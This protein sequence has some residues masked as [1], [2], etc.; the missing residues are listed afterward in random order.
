M[1][2]VLVDCTVYGISSLTESSSRCERVPSPAHVDYG[3]GTARAS[4]KRT[5]RRAS[6]QHGNAQCADSDC[7]QECCLSRFMRTLF[8]LL[9][10]SLQLPFPHLYQWHATE[11]RALLSERDNCVTRLVVSAPSES[12]HIVGA[13]R[14]NGPYLPPVT[15]NYFIKI[16]T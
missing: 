11:P 6:I 5:C 8:F 9:L 3:R 7:L 1:A 2:G 10:Q 4:P 14:T 16:M 13:V 12:D 15:I